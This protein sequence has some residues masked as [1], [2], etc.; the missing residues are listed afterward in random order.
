MSEAAVPQPICAGTALQD[1]GLGVRFDVLVGGRLTPAFVIRYDGRVYGYLNQC[2]HVPME[3]D[4]AEGQ[5]FETSGLYLMCA[6]H[7]ATY[8]PDTGHCV[9]GPCRGGALQPV[10]VEEQSDAASGTT[11]VWWPDAYIQVPGTSA[12]TA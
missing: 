2:A 6:T 10:R 8:E 1:G 9:G 11:V 3:L 5:F 4:W 12:S 7:G